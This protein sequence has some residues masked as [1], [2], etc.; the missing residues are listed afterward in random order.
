MKMTAKDYVEYLNNVAKIIADNKDYV[1]ELDA[2]TGDGDHWANVNMGFSQLVAMG[3]ELAT[4][5]ISDMFKKIAMTMMSG[6]GG[7]S[8]V[9]YGSAFLKAAMV[10]K[11]A[12]AIDLPLLVKIIEAE[13]EGIMT[14]GKA[15]PGFKTMIDPLYQS[16]QAMRKAFDEGKDEKEVLTAMKEGAIA[17]MKATAEMEAVRGRACYQPDKG[18]GH[19]DPGAVTMCYQLEAL[20]DYLM[21]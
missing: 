9:L 20:A 16:A 4:M 17:G 12:E 13:L 21:K 18:V 3:D 19:L 10:S 6:I 8:G 11:D 15:E 1:T 5:S 2:V 14:R 7:S